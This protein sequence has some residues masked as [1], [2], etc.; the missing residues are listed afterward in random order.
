MPIRPDL[1][2]CYPANWTE[3]SHRVRF[4][5]AGGVC[6]RCGRPHR[7]RIRCLPDG[8]WF[9]PVLNTWRD[10]NGRPAS[11]PDLI[12]ATRQRFTYVVLA[13][14]HLD[15]DP[16]N[17]RLRNLR[18]LCQRCHML[19]DRPYHRAQ[20]RLTFMMRRAV[21]DLFLGPYSRNHPMP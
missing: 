3:I 1:R 6:E 9:D 7:Q 12:E 16:T 20:R 10:D 13:T 14:A 15:H 17:N 19:N 5:R 11:W 21:G 18:S 8:R 2:P 4:T